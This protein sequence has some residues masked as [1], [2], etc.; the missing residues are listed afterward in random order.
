MEVS[1]DSKRAHI[2]FLQCLGWVIGMC[3]LPMIAWIL[4]DWSL[5]MVFTTIPCAIYFFMF[6]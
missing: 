5:L 1:A 6:K 3:A 4:K 2:A